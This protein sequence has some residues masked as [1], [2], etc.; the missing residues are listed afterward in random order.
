MIP[1]SKRRVIV[2]GGDEWEYCIRGNYSVNIFIHNMRTSEKL[3][4]YMDGDGRITPKDIKTI[5]E[6]KKLANI[7]ARN[8]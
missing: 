3:S 2:V 8:I 1:K 6:T 4:W 7:E 5:I